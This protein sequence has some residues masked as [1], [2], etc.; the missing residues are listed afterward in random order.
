MRPITH[1][2]IHHSATPSGDVARFRKEHQ[3]RGYSDIGYHEVIGN[4]KGLPDGHIS[5]GRPHEQDGAGVYGNNSG[6]LQVCLIGNFERS[7]QGYTGKPSP[8]QM[9]ALGHWLHVN[10][11]RYGMT[12]YRKVV[13]HREITLAGHGTACPGSEMPLRE[14]RLWF[15]ANIEKS[16]PEPL[17][18]YLLRDGYRFEA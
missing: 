4:G 8:R 16:E 18:Q 7:D 1:L 5:R 14:I 12:D 13:G 2:V 9:A 10:G 17:D 3:A 15:L 11:R 6:K